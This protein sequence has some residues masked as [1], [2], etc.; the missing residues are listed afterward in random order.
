M[1]EEIS[2]KPMSKFIKWFS[3]TVIC[4]FILSIFG[5]MV[6][7]ITVGDKSFGFLNSPVKSLYTFPD[8]FSQS[9]EEVSSYPQTFIKTPENFESINQ[10]DTSVTMLATYS[11]TAGGRIV[12][13][14]D[15]KSGNTNHSW[16]IDNP[17]EDHARIWNPIV[18]EDKSLIY[19]FEC[20]TG[21][22]RIDAKG[23]LIWKQDSVWN[24][25]SMELGSDGNIWICGF[26]PTYEAT[27]MHTL[28]GDTVYYMDNFISKIDIKSGKVLYHESITD[29]LKENG[30]INYLMKS[31]V[32]SDPIHINDIQPALK[33]TEYYAEGDLFISARNLSFI[34]H[35]RPSTNEVIE[36]IEGPFACQHDVDFY[37]DSVLVFFNNNAYP[38]WTE[39][40]K[41]KPKN[42]AYMNNAGDFYSNV[43]SYNLSS[44]RFG[45][46][47]EEVFRENKIFTKTEGR[48]QFLDSNTYFI[49]EQNSGVLWII[50]GDEVIYKDVLKSKIPGYHHLPN[51]N[52]IM[53]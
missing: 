39:S 24:H 35:F 25:H 36:V 41:E 11:D 46:I 27:G 30:L 28:D 31:S 40:S 1:T 43:V 16:E 47:G 32:I 51:W 45:L 44:K 8:L 48:V 23:K 26:Q 38:L 7:H 3:Y 53:N 50:R 19:A 18:L 5:W 52:R 20:M 15:L 4:L 22:R 21:L 2:G 10:L 14:I 9:V 42:S 33:T 6:H 13:L 12:A 37:N 17:F 49:E 29:I 34:M